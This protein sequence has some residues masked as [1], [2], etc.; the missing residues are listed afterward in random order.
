MKQ[1]VN[2]SAFV[3]AFHA[4]DRYEY[5]GYDGLRIIFDYLEEYEESAGEELELDV[6]A[7]CCDYNMM[8]IATIASEYNIETESKKRYVA[9]WNMPGYLPDSD[10]AEFDDEND[11]LEYIK[12]A[13][14]ESADA[15]NE[16]DDF[17]AGNQNI[18]NE[19]CDADRKT[20]DAWET[21][22]NGEFGKT[23]G[24]YH[25]WISQDGSMPIDQDEQHDAVIEYLNDN[26][27]VLDETKDG[28]VVFTVF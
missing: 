27:I 1:S 2:F 28:Q 10:P 26:T 20:I 7:I 3:D 12:E 5:F 9:G 17:Y 25:Y 8:D 24:N 18:L 22:K 4:F 16:S 15:E 21:D 14:K 13:A 23:F 6:I 11:A 19:A